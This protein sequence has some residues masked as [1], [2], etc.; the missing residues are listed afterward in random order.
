MISQAS[1]NKPTV[2]RTRWICDTTGAHLLPHEIKTYHF[3]GSERVY[4]TKNE[5]QELKQFGID[6]H[7][8]LLGFADLSSLRP[9]YSLK[10]P[11]FLRPDDFNYPGSGKI[12]TAL[13]RRMT[14]RSK[15]AYVSFIPTGVSMPRVYVMVPQL[16][17]IDDET[18]D[19]ASAAGFNLIAMPYRQE[20]RDVGSE[21]VQPN[22]E[23]VDLIEPSESQKQ[24]AVDLV[25][26]ARLKGFSPSDYENPL[27]QH[28]YATVEALAL[29][30][31]SEWNSE[32]DDTVRP[33]MGMKKK[34]PL[35]KSFADAFEELPGLV[36]KTKKKKA[37]KRKATEG[38]ESRE[39]K[40]A[41]KVK[42]DITWTEIEAKGNIPKNITVPQL[43]ALCKEKG[44]K[45]T[46]KKADLMSR[47]EGVLLL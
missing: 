2:V 14:R 29:G 41:K 47:L 7:L 15:M 46:G 23:F 9:E 18:G 32:L 26:K 22:N 1:N 38:G 4:L 13:H 5:T 36:K 30:N 35:M 6:R 11:Y 16:E 44:L 20:I 28:H 37:T 31:K 21:I 43:K 40:K 10:S 39:K 45:A 34:E 19:V 8:R 24:V 42:A 12:F 17:I 27:L 33:P 25:R 3:Y